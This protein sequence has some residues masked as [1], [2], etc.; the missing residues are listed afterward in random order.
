MTA[1]RARRPDT[2]GALSLVVGWRSGDEIEGGRVPLDKGVAASLRDICIEAADDVATRYRRQYS[3]EAHLEDNEVFVL[4]RTQV[5]TGTDLLDLLD[6]T[7]ELPLLEVASLPAKTLL[8]YAFVIGDEIGKRVA[9]VRKKNSATV[10]KPGKVLAVLGPNTLSRIA[11]AVFTFDNNIDLV[12]DAS[13]VTVLNQHAFE[14]LFRQLEAMLALV[15]SWIQ[16]I[17]ETIPLSEPLAAHLQDRAR[18]DSRIRHRLLVIDERGHL[19]NVTLDE[20]VTEAERQELDTNGLV[21]DGALT[22][23]SLDEFT[24]LRLLNEDLFRG[25]LTDQRFAVDRKSPR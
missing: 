9:F 16:K 25:G 2:D 14:T 13:E 19:V 20:V 23:G 10:A 15:P 24:L 1:T 22:L 12:V 11:G 3:A 8:F 6:R 18:T 7:D 5:T 21:V 4:S 17:H